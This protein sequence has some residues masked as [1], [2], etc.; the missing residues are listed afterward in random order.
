MAITEC[1]ATETNVL[2]FILNVPRSGDPSYIVTYYRKW[3]ATYL[4]T[5][6]NVGEW[7]EI[8]SISS[9]GTGF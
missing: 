3:V 7:M 4:L 6:R 8:I 5:F 1:F 2:K 9:L